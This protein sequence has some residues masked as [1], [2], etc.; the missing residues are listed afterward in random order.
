[1]TI[2]WKKLAQIAKEKEGERKQIV[3]KEKLR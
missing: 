3:E 2:L 1:L